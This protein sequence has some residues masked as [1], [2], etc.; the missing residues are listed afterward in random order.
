MRISL[1]GILLLIT[2]VGLAVYHFQLQQRISSTKVKIAELNAKLAEGHP[3]LR[4]SI[5]IMQL[6]A[7][8]PNPE[9]KFHELVISEYEKEIASREI[10]ANL[11]S[12]QAVVSAIVDHRETTELKFPSCG[13]FN[14]FIPGNQQWQIEIER[15]CTLTTDEI[16]ALPK[17]LDELISLSKSIRI[18]LPSG[19]SKL[20]ADQEWHEKGKRNLLRF[21]LN[22][23]QVANVVLDKPDMIKLKDYELNLDQAISFI[24]NW[25]RRTI[26]SASQKTYLGCFAQ[27]SYRPRHHRECGKCIGIRYWLS[28]VDSNAD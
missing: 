26:A 12:D 3:N 25:S 14:F 16:E 11:I 7:K 13:T 8:T 15:W 17:P 24:P 2:L 23:K 5:E 10:P 20:T 9:H 6:A 22:D 18:P 4:R 19:I 28:R 21:T 27:Q 1:L